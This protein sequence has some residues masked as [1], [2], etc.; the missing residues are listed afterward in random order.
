MGWRFAPRLERYRLHR[1]NGVPTTSNDGNDQHI[2]GATSVSPWRIPTVSSNTVCRLCENTFVR[3]GEAV[4]LQTDFSGMGLFVTFLRSCER[5]FT[6]KKFIA[7]YF[8]TFYELDRYELAVSFFQ[9]AQMLDTM[10]L[11]ANPRG[12]S[13]T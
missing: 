6:G 7:D 3:H 8:D 12:I 5:R 2:I 9:Q 1:V 10:S 11:L 4:G 13:A